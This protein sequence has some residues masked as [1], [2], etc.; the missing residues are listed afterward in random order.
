[1]KLRTLLRT[2]SLNMPPLYTSA[3]LYTTSLPGDMTFSLLRKVPTYTLISHT[4]TH[5]LLSSPLPS[6]PLPPFSLFSFFL[7]LSLFLFSFFLSLFLPLS[8]SS[9]FWRLE[10]WLSG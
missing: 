6:P 8:F 10:R 3:H 9:S 7:F 1:M 2:F 5:S 4:N